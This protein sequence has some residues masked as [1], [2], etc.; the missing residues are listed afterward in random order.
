MFFFQ[1]V[2]LILVRIL[3]RTLVFN[4]KHRINE[5]CFCSLQDSQS[6]MGLHQGSEQQ[7]KCTGTRLSNHS[8]YHNPRVFK[9]NHSLT[10]DPFLFASGFAK[11]DGFTPRQRA[12]GQTHGHPSLQSQFAVSRP[13]NQHFITTTVTH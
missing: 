6:E 9:R 8:S 11:R 5:S 10:F 12:T 13:Q 3:K 2:T 1:L 7:G 4:A